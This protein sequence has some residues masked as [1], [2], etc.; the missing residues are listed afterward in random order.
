MDILELSDGSKSAPES[1]AFD[2]EKLAAGGV[3]GGW[4]YQ[5]GLRVR[6][7]GV[8]LAVLSE[9][10]P[11]YQ[12]KY[13]SDSLDAEYYSKDRD[14]GERRSYECSLTARRDALSW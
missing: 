9:S 5:S 6:Y 14:Q 10:G 11:L 2:G 13:G 3:R 12:A 8:Y 4:G 1:F 7:T